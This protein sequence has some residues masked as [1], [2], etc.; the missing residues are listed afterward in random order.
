[1]SQAPNKPFAEACEINKHPIL[2]VLRHYFTD[3]GLVLEIGAGTGQHAIHF[4]S[5]LK[6]LIW[7]PSDL[8]V[9]LAGMQLW[10]DEVDLENLRAP[11]ALDVCL[12]DWRHECVDYA[13]SSNTVHIMSWPQVVCLFELLA[14]AMHAG[15]LFVLYGPFKYGDEHTS[16]SNYDFDLWLRARDPQSGVRDVYELQK[17]AA[18]NQ[19]E[20]IADKEMPINN[21]SLIWRKL[22]P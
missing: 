6:H 13:Y 22:Q 2:E 20:L 12:N 7:W 18:Q 19:I 16:Q 10:F 11:M 9:N 5:N 8:A 1:M 21:R 15:A 17:L 4:A 14:K 3:P